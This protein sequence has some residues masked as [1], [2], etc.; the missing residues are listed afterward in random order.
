MAIVVEEEK[1]RGGI[2]VLIGWLV[3]ILTIVLAVYLI[4]FKNPEIVENV[5]PASF[6]QTAQVAQIDLK[7]DVF[8]NPAFT[9]RQSIGRSIQ[10]PGEGTVGKRNPFLP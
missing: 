4:F 2:I 6:R 8:R 7:V 10:A 5:A 3:V 1:D 9:T